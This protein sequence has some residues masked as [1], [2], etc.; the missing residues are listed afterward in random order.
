MPEY[1]QFLDTG[2]EIINDH[3]QN[4]AEVL[5]FND[6]SKGLSHSN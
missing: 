1:E 5:D 3:F 2:T 6:Q 4:T